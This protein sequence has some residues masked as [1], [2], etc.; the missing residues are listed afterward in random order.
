MF[1]KIAIVSPF[2]GRVGHQQSDLTES[3][4]E[5]TRADLQSSFV[6]FAGAHAASYLEVGSFVAQFV[7]VFVLF[8]LYRYAEP[9]SSAGKALVVQ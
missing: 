1:V 3:I 8:T 4:C 7:H 2:E 9:P 5:L 6:R